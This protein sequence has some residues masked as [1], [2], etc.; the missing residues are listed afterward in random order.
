MFTRHAIRAFACEKTT[1]VIV[2]CSSLSV[3]LVF[4]EYS[5]N[6]HWMFTECSLNI[7]W[8]FTGCSLDVYPLHI[9]DIACETITAVIVQ[10]SL[11]I[12]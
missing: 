1:S 7:H 10:C 3:H 9:R 11:N 4:T 5:L 12:H 8:M 2:P 6:I